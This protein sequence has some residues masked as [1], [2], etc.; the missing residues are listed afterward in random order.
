MRLAPQPRPRPAHAHSA[1]VDSHP[2]PQARPPSLV[3]PPRAEPDGSGPRS[4]AESR[5]KPAPAGGAGC[6]GA[7]RGPAPKPAA[8]P[9]L[10]GGRRGEPMGGEHAGAG[11][12]GAGPGCGCCGPSSPARLSQTPAARCR[13]RR[14]RSLV[15]WYPRRPSGGGEAAPRHKG[16]RR[17]DRAEAS[18]PGPAGRRHERLLGHPVPG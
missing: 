4:G 6:A 8:R 2:S 17:G 9:Y 11:R 18:G 15:R 14:R 10:K 13:R 1:P 5:G 16:G 7:E 12:G 3:L